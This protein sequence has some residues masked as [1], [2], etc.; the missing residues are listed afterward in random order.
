MTTSPVTGSFEYGGH[1]LTYD[2]YG[3][4]EH[5]IVYL[6][7]LLLDAD[8]N[9]GIAEALSDRGEW[10]VL[11]DLLGHGGSDRPTR[12]MEYRIDSYAD[13]VVA[14]LDHLGVDRATLG[15]LSLGA[16][17]SLFTAVEH[18]TRVRGLVLEMPVMEWAV[19]SAAM[20]FVPML[21]AAH[22][23]R[24][25]HPGDRGVGRTA[26]PHPLRTAEQRARRRLHAPRC[27]VRDP[28]RRARRS[29]RPDRGAAPPDH[30]ADVGAGAHQRP[31]PP[32]QRRSEPGGRAPRRPARP[33]ALTARAAPEPR[34]P[35]RRDRRVRGRG[36]VGRA[37]R[38][39]SDDTAAR[40]VETHISRL[41]FVDDRVIKVKLPITTP[42]VDLSTVE[43]RGLAAEREV[44][45]NRRLAADVYLGVLD[46]SMGD[47]VVEH[48]VLM[49]R[50]PEDRRLARR[51]DH[52]AATA[53]L[54]AIADAVAQL[55][56]RSPHRPEID[57]AASIDAVRNLWT[58]GLEQLRPFA[59][60]ILEPD[61][62]D[63]LADLVEEY[64][65]GRGPLF[66]E[67]I[68]QGWACDGH[69]DLQAED[70]FCLDD[71]PRILDCLEFDDHLR[72]GDALNDAGFLAMDL[73]RLGHPDLG[74]W[75]LAEYRRLHA[76]RGPDSLARHYMAYRAHVRSKV[77]CI[78]HAQHGRDSDADDREIAAR[79][80]ARPARSRA[81][82]DGD[83]RRVARHREVD[84][85]ACARGRDGR[86]Q[87]VDRRDPRRAV[88]GG[89]GAPVRPGID[90]CRLSGAPRANGGGARQGRARGGRRVL[91]AR[92]TPRDGPQRRGHL[93]LGDGGAAVHL[94]DRRGRGAHHAADSPPAA[95]RRRR[96]SRSPGR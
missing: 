34:T 13:Q 74:E 17:V 12:A 16:N 62:I 72:F 52:P 82:A 80:G 41:F 68:A 11:L 3:S 2:E 37:G 48:A 70:I 38:A 58:E 84:V 51:L 59:P 89:R 28:P 30:H 23:G 10:V 33:G 19:P 6:H 56:A 67:R 8:L 63:R 69:G 39:V 47:D 79:P 25:G 1:R 78:R 26:A 90:R 85:V 88:P 75:F 66:E 64:L 60:A 61:H 71:G 36:V 76:D 87:V 65:D 21:L 45:L 54:T 57:L 73:G 95:T 15:G 91:A 32:V 22:Y 20:A 55:H 42:F 44:S 7:G 5:P 96:R 83:G 77:A 4:G 49:R 93:T 18:P 29:G 94:P 86:G 40:I 24:R 53:D 14:L 46:V 31:D 9:R 35:H 50:L 43:L 27:D 81:G 92:S